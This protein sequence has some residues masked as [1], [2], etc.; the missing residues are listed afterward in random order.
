MSTSS[1]YTLTV[2]DEYAVD[3]RMA[4]IEEMA[5]DIVHLRDHRKDLFEW[6]ERNY[7]KDPEGADD[8]LRAT[9]GLLVRDIVLA[10]H[11]DLA[12]DGAIEIQTDDV[13]TLAHACETMVRTV[14]GPRFADN[15]GYSP[16]DEKLAEML[17]P[18]IDS[19]KWAIDQAAGLHAAGHANREKPEAA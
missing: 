6:L 7:D 12:G 17:Y 2:P 19:L 18:L 8:D 14:V 13:E 9:T 15:L 16:I 11:V 4:L 3:F 5:L 10:G 1:G